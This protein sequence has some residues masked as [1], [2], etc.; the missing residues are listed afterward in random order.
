MSIILKVRRN[1]LCLTSSKSEETHYIVC[2][3]EM[4]TM[5]LLL[6]L[7]MLLH[8]ASFTFGGAFRKTMHSQVTEK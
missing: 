8:Q 5:P 1:T 6:P 2:R 3:W 4:V 7:P